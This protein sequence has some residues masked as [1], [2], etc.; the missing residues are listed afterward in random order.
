M[1][2]LRFANCLLCSC[3]RDAV[4]EIIREMTDPSYLEHD[5]Y[6][7]LEAIMD[8]MA[9]AYCPELAVPSCHSTPSMLATTEADTS[10]SP[11]YDQMNGIHHHILS[12]CDPPTAR[13]LSK[14]GVE[15]QMFLLRWVRVLMSREFEMPQVWQLW[16]AIFSLTPHDFSFINVLCVAAVREFRDE[17]LQAEDATAVLLC[18]R[19]LSDKVEAD[20]LVENARELY[21]ALLLAAAVEAAEAHAV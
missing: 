6:L 20:R 12:R 19:D 7:L 3:C 14:L 17:I 5:A 16:D 2:R 15:P 13:H 10:S 11:L 21:D 4:E 8:R 18:L 1:G 9:G